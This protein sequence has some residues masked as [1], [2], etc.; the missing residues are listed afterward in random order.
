MRTLF[1]ILRI[2]VV[3]AITVAIVAQLSASLG[4]WRESG[5]TDPTTQVVNFFSFFTIESNVASAVV[6]AIGAVLL[7]V[8]QGP[9]G[10]GFTL[11]RACVT[12]Y[13][14]VTGIVYN[15]LLRG[16]ELPQGS[17]VGWSN[18]ILHVAA[19]LYLL[20]DWILAPGRSRLAARKIWLV[21]VYPIVWVV[22]TLVRGPFVTDVIYGNE[23]WYPYP[24]LNPVTS[25][26]GYLSVA[27]YVVAIAA[28]IALIAAGV[29][30]VSRRG[31]TDGSRLLR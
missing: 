28:A 1:V 4:F 25:D 30:W 14:I 7:I 12:S 3:V 17:T 24:F 31:A 26:G 10:Q 9:D 15:L 13:M 27:I 20:I 19:P 11:A 2:A 23:Y 8:R 16:I 29:L 22:Y 5:V 21:L 6:L 18:E